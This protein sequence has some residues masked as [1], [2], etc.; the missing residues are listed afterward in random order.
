[1]LKSVQKDTGVMD[2]K[3]MLKVAYIFTPPWDPNYPSYAMALFSASTKKQGEQFFGFDNPE[4][5]VAISIHAIESFIK[6]I[7]KES[8]EVQDV[9]P[10][11]R[12]E[13][14][15]NVEIDVKVKLL[16]S[17]A[18]VPQLAD[19]I[20][21]DIKHKVQNVLGIDNVASV[22]I[23][24]EKDSFVT[25]QQQKQDFYEGPIAV[26]SA[27]PSNTDSDSEF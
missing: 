11:I 14:D 12:A 16:A 1:M 17:A 23:I 25:V 22:R 3:G 5:E 10:L 24:L 8:A 2:R 27:V 26:S 7:T 4:G 9:T 6:K 20:Q 19:T 13:H 15:G 21:K 18:N